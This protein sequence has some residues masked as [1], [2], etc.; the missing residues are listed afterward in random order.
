MECIITTLNNIFQKFGQITGS[1]IS[2]LA[3]WRLNTG[4]LTRQAASAPSSRDDVMPCY[5][6]FG[7]TQP[8]FDEQCEPFNHLNICDIYHPGQAP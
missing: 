1:G 5:Q 6:S 8:I 2:D 4:R 7:E 3:N